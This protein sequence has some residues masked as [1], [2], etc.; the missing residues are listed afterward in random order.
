MNLLGIISMS[1]SYYKQ[2]FYFCTSSIIYKKV[3]TIK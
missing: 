2:D 3:G 1:Y